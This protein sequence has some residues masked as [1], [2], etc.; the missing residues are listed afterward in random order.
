M[1]LRLN[2]AIATFRTDSQGLALWVL[3]IAKDKM[4]V[5]RIVPGPDWDVSCSHVWHGVALVGILSEFVSE[6]LLIITRQVWTGMNYRQTS[7]VVPSLPGT[8]ARSSVSLRNEGTI[9]LDVSEKKVNDMR[10][11]DRWTLGGQMT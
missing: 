11:D 7:G 10:G 8:S 1:Q 4:G 5:A 6:Y 3:E 9:V 2:Y